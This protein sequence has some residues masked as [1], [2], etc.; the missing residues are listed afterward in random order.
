MKKAGAWSPVLAVGV[1]FAVLV[2]GCPR[3]R[4]CGWD[5]HLEVGGQYGLGFIEAY[6]P[7]ITTAVYDPD[8]DV[9][10]NRFDDLPACPDIDETGVGRTIVVG[11]PVQPYPGRCSWWHATIDE[12]E[13]SIEMDGGTLF[14]NRGYNM[15]VAGGPRD[16][17][18]GCTGYWELVVH[19]PGLD[20]FAAPNPLDRPVVVAYRFFTAELESVDA[21]FA[22]LGLDPSTVEHPACAD[23]YVAAMDRR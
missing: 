9:V 12:P 21:C 16:L 19:A 4:P 17:G 6:G 2:A 5:E 1:G 7:D 14:N 23:A 18:A 10:V 15:L 20:P 13:S 11:T 3:Y 8:L 22:L